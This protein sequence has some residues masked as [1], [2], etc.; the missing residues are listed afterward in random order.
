MT[1]YFVD[2]MRFIVLTLIA[3]GLFLANLFFGSV[4]LPAGEVMRILL[5]EPADNEAAAFIILESRLPQAVTATLAGAALTVA[6]LMLQTAFRNP[7]AG[8]SILGITSGSSL[9]VALVM[10]LF[11][12]SITAAGFTWGGYAAVITGAFLGSAAIMGILLLLSMALKNDLMLLIAGIMV[13]YLASSVIT[14]LNYLSTAE[15]VHSYTM[16]GMGN[17]NGVGISQLPVFSIS[18]AVGLLLSVLL[19]KPLN[20]VLLG[21]NYARNLG[22]SMLAV[23]NLLLVSTGILTSIVTAYCGP[24]S[25]I[26]LAVPHIARMVFRTADHRIIIPGCMLTGAVVGLLCNL[27]SVIPESIV[28]PLN[29]VTPLIGVPVILYVILKKRA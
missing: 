28:L 8:P 4:S 14:L 23:R 13:G 1:V 21:E 2:F 27:I 15:G 26:G 9:G 11:G 6:G 22:I 16:W 3:A 12:G 24:I 7:L 20:V 29:G 25:F 5:G 19:V 10:L 18:I 17:F